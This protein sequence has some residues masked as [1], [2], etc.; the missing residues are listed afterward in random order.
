MDGSKIT[1]FGCK[2]EFNYLKRE[3]YDK[4]QMGKK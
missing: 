1:A 2:L 4:Y 3:I